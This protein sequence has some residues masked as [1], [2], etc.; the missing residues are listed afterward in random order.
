MGSKIN[1]VGEENYNTFGSRMV[2]V[3]YRMRRD[4]DVYFP[5]YDWT[6]KNVEYKAFKNGNIKCPYERRTF[7]VGYLG[8]G[9]YKTK[10]N[11]KNTRVYSVWKA[12]LQR[13]YDEKFKENRPTYKDCKVSEEWLCF[14]NFA[15]W[16]YE[17]Y[18]EIEGEKMCLDKDILIKHNKIY[19]PDNCIFVPQRIN[20]LFIKNDK[21]RGDNPIGVSDA[22][23]G[24]YIVSCNL[25]RLKTGKSK[26][27][28]L[29]GYETQEEAF[30]VYKYYKESNIKEVADYYFGRIP[31][32]IYDRLYNYEVE[33]DD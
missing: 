22:I 9:K 11:G 21:D 25:F 14:Q 16:F 5:E 1:R 33:I 19:S 17:N 15:K 28:Y 30:K 13:C 6:A 3:E 8:E 31:Q 7:G 12:M 2:I 24:K 27:E 18:Y 20:N 29:G 26:Y 32:K 4:M 23:N 10:K